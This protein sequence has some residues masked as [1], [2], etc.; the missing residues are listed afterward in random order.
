MKKFIRKYYFLV[1]YIK[2]HMKTNLFDQA[3]KA[4]WEIE[5]NSSVFWLELNEGLVH[6]ALVYQLAN[7]RMVVAHTKTRWDRRGSTRKIYKQKQCYMLL[8]SKI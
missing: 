1:T 6:R 3:W 4:I 8:N 7:N 5:L 2:L